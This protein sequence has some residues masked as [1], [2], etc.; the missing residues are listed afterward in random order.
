[1][2]LTVMLVAG[3]VWAAVLVTSK[4]VQKSIRSGQDISF[5]LDLDCATSVAGINGEMRYDTLRLSDPRVAVG[6][7]APGF[8]VVGNIV[9]PGRFKFVVYKSPTTSVDLSKVVV[10]FT[11]KVS[12][13]KAASTKVTYAISAAAKPDG[14]SYGSS[15]SFADVMLDLANGA[16]SW[17]WY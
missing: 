5:G 1:M 6:S 14:V 12:S 3:S 11:L 9:E 7:G 4:P 16:Q 2:I 10:N 17:T 15:V 8:T 13:S